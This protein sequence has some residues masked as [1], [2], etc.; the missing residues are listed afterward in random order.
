MLRW[1]IIILAVILV[2]AAVYVSDQ[3]LH[4]F[5]SDDKSEL[6]KQQ[7]PKRVYSKEDLADIEAFRGKPHFQSLETMLVTVFSGDRP[8]RHV[9]LIVTAQA[10]SSEAATVIFNRRDELSSELTRDMSRFLSLQ[11][12]ESGDFDQ[13]FVGKRLTLVGKRVLGDDI[14]HSILIQTIVSRRPAR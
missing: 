2:A 10:T 14:L 5:D 3:K 13:Y 1:V 8:I 9:E 4:L 7:T 6:A 12:E 11:Y